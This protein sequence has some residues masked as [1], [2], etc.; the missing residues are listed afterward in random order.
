MVDAPRGASDAFLAP[1]HIER[2]KIFVRH[3][4]RN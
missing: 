3:R 4:C 1:Y 2:G